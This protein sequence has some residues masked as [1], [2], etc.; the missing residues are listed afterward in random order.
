M[1]GTIVVLSCKPASIPQRRSFFANLSDQVISTI[2]DYA[3]QSD[4]KVDEG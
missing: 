4:H 3:S 1:D 2:V